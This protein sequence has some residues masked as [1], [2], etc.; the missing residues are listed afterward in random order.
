MFLLFVEKKTVK[1][2][3]E[4]GTYKEDPESFI[5]VFLAKADA[6]KD[7]PET[8]FT[9]EQLVVVVL[10]LIL[11]GS[12]TSSNTLNFGILYML[13][14]P[15]VQEKVQVEL[16]CVLAEGEVITSDMKTRLP[17]TNATVLEILRQSTVVQLPS[18]REATEDFYFRGRYFIPKGMSCMPNIYA[19]H[20]DKEVWGDPQN[21]RPER[22]L[23]QSETEVKQEVAGKLLSFGA[24]KRYCLGQ[25]L[26]ECTMFLYFARIM[27]EFTFEKI[28]GTNPTEEPVLGLTL[29]PHPY[30]VRILKRKVTRAVI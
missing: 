14:N 6:C 2:H 28:P 9:D 15:K 13:L 5:D 10:D 25:S 7:D 29:I 27:K 30:P 17:Y 24:G 20:H 19:I 12:E 23:N 16:D 26:A 21:F 3:R 4:Q 8:D 18:P 1:E 11:G 22:F